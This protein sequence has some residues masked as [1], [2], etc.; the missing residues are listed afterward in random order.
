MQKYEA[1]NKIKNWYWLLNPEIVTSL[2][3]QH[4][5][6]AINPAAVSNWPQ[7]LALASM[8]YHKHPSPPW[9]SQYESS[10]QAQKM[11]NTQINFCI[12]SS[13]RVKS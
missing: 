11:K 13:T 12:K 3:A 6:F 10:T 8:L 9:S 7:N 5:S 4:K 2:Q 1:N